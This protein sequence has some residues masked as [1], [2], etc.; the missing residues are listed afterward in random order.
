VVALSTAEAEYV[1]LSVA[2][3][4]AV[5]LRRLFTLS[6]SKNLSKEGTNATSSLSLSHQSARRGSV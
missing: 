2:A 6:E 4:E 1:A 3:Q 5:R